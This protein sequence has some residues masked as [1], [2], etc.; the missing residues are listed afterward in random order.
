M[1][2]IQHTQQQKRQVNY[3]ISIC[4]DA[5]LVTLQFDIHGFLIPG[6]VA[7]AIA[8]IVIILTCITNT[9]A[10]PAGADPKEH[11]KSN[12]VV[13]IVYLIV[14]VIAL[15]VGLILFLYVGLYAK[16]LKMTN[17]FAIGLSFNEKYGNYNKVVGNMTVCGKCPP[18]AVAELKGYND[19]LLYN[20]ML[21]TSYCEANGDENSPKF[22]STFSNKL[23]ER[24]GNYLLLQ[25][26]NAAA[27]MVGSIIAIVYAIMIM[28]VEEGKS[29]PVAPTKPTEPI[30][31][32]A[33]TAAVN[34][35]AE[36]KATAI[37]VKTSPKAGDAVPPAPATKEETKPLP[38]STPAPVTAP[39]A[40]APEAPA[41]PA[42][43]AARPGARPAPGGAARPAAPG[44]RPAAGGAARPR[45]AGAA[46]PRAAAPA[47]PRAAR[48]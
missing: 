19:G 43:P 14:S 3:F 7:L 46:R 9:G 41:K 26:F 16:N 34:K 33:A 48:P 37:E 8:L 5:F 31:V 30:K 18:L 40:P 36:A 12:V 13:I 17:P 32:P 44:A 45:P 2:Q 39:E 11:K 21:C 1:P 27:I 38:E 24:L 23:Y 35:P 4:T 25:L 47:R 22:I 15:I 10:A 29:S 28:N 20:H 6:V 42:A